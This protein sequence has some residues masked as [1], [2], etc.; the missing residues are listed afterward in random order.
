MNLLYKLLRAYG[1]FMVY[2]ILLDL[3]Y[4]KFVI[5]QDIVVF[6]LIL[7]FLWAPFNTF[8]LYL[9]HFFKI[10]HEILKKTMVI[11]ESVIVTICIFTFTLI[12]AR[13]DYHVV[14]YEVQGN[15]IRNWYVSDNSF[16]IYSY[17][18]TLLVFVFIG[19][20]H[21]NKK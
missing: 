18:I 3:I 19:R 13:L 14:F 9:I 15:I 8:F 12:R 1:I 4:A 2:C 16:F 21:V 20:L 17:I 11:L 5:D 7:L 6:G 10:Y